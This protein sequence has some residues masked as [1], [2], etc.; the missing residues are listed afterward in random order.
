MLID[1]RIGQTSIVL[2]V[3]I[4]NSSV[5]TGAG[6]TGLTSSSTGLRI[7]TIA[8]NEATSTAYTV[9]G[10]TIETVTT[11]GTFANPTATKCRFREVDS[12]NHPGI[13]ELQIDNTRFAVTSARSLLISI[14]GA[15]NAAECD[16]MIPLRAVD[17]YSAAG[18]MTGVNGIAPPANWNLMAIDGSGRVDLGKILGTASAGVAGYVG[19]D[20]SHVNAPT[21]TVALSGTTI[22][23]ATNVTTK[24]AV[25]LAATDVTGNL[26]A[27]LQT[28]KTQA[29]TAAAPVTV[30]AS[31][32]TAATST[33]QT[34][35]SFARIGAAGAGLTALGDTRLANLDA[36]VSTRSTY[37]GADTAGTT[38]LLG[39]L[40]TGRATNLDN[41]D[42]AVST[43]LATAG[44][45]T[46]P[47]TAAIAT[48]LWQDTVPG[49]FT[50]AGSPGRLLMNQLAGAF[51]GTTSVYTT[52]RSESVV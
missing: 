5:A 12:T 33:A 13:Y 48:A 2:R 21:S 44:Y 23:T 11:L 30:L 24:L 10:A 4:R 16:V 19:L 6:L 29:V 45:T 7:G 42:A 35:D 40:T 41:L 43:R 3:K 34:G 1:Y 37:A 22:G 36:A 18:F 27:D 20:W 38:T 14:S 47:T 28:I 50:T 17:P 46:P 32:G 52:A 9:A 51:T 25:S 8:D 39:R 26:P 31:V 15:T 49:D